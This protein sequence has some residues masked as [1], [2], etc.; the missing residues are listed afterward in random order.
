MNLLLSTMALTVLMVLS[1]SQAAKAENCGGGLKWNQ[2]LGRCAS[3]S[4]TGTNST[5]TGMSRT[6]SGSTSDIGSTSTGS[7]SR[8]TSGIGSAGGSSSN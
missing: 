5:D 2:S 3:E 7:G 1:G 8:S 4:G 6:G